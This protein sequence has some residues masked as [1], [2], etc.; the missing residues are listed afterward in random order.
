MKRVVRFFS[1][2]FSSNCILTPTR[3]HVDHEQINQMK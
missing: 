3:D 2:N 1:I